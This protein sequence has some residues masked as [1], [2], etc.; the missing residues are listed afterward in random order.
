M[1]LKSIFTFLTSIPSLINSNKKFELVYH[2]FNFKFFSDD[3][4]PTS[5]IEIEPNNRGQNYDGIHPPLLPNDLNQVRQ[6]LPKWQIATGVSTQ[7]ATLKP[8]SAP[9]KATLLTKNGPQDVSS[10]TNHHHRPST[11]IFL[12]S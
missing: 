4:E 1:S 10:S 12:F 6:V 5:S 9:Q 11:Y 2:N 3:R 8:G 7:R